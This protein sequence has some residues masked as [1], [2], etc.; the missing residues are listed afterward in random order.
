[1]VK[2]TH[3]E[4]FFLFIPF[5]LI[6]IWYIASGLKLKQKIETL[7]STEVHNFLLNRVRFKKVKL[8]SQLLFL[9]FCFS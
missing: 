3:P 7:G 6:I 8:R 5:F 2:Y 4:M 1:M 9:L